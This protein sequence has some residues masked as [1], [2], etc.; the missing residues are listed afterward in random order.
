MDETGSKFSASCLAHQVIK[1][2]KEPTGSIMVT[3]TCHFE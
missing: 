3:L 1:R 2:K